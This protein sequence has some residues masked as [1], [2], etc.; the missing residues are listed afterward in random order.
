MLIIATLS[1]K[2]KEE[3]NI[4]NKI[5]LMLISAG[6]ILLVEIAMYTGFTPIGAEF[7]GGVQGRYFIPVYILL[8][9]CL[10]KKNNYVKIKNSEN[11]YALI[12]AI[13]NL[14]V[15][16]ETILYFA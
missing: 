14:C 9:L 13:L 10:S 16:T 6:V 1:E 5:W 3:F 12:S 8:L 2:N 11:I 7:I 4:K 15:I